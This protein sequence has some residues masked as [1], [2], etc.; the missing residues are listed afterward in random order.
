MLTVKEASTLLNLLQREVA[1]DD[2]FHQ[3]SG[4][5]CEEFQGH[6]FMLADVL[7]HKGL[8]SYEPRVPP[9]GL[10]PTRK[11]LT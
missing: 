5:E 11:G 10:H 1:K 7:E 2:F 9:E 6:V 3:S 8:L 4:E